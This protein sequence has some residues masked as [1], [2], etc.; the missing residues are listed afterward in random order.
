MKY[1]EAELAYQE[2]RAVLHRRGK[3]VGKTVMGRD[4]VRY[5]IVDGLLL[6][7]RDLF[8]EAWGGSLADEI[9]RERTDVRALQQVV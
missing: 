7:D 3:T 8:T 9:L 5:C 2:A 6:T 4:D 1:D